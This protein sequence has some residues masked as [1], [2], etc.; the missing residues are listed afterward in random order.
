VSP[1]WDPF[2][3][4]ITPSGLT[5]FRT[6]VVKPYLQPKPKPKPESEDK[7]NK[8]ESAEQGNTLQNEQPRQNTH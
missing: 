5:D 6:T 7:K 3:W 8:E 2:C 4:A 1:L